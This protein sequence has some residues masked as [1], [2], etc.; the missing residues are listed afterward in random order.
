M[1]RPR[2]VVATVLVLIAIA[3][4]VIALVLIERSRVPGVPSEMVPPSWSEYRTSLGHEAHI[5]KDHIECRDCHDYEKEGFRSPGS[6][7]C[8]RCHDKQGSHGHGGGSKSGACLDCH[9]FAPNKTTPTCISCHAQAQ[10]H[11]AK[12]EHHDTTRCADCHRPHGEPS[13]VEKDCK[14]CHEELS[15]KHAAHAGSKGC[16]DCHAPHAP[17]AAAPATCSS[18]HTSPSGPKP[19][20]HE[21]CSTCHKPHEFVAGGSSV[22]S[23]CHGQKP[24]L[25]AT[26]VPA[27]AA[28]TSC[29]APHAP[30]QAAASCTYCHADV[31]VSHGGGQVCVACHQPHGSDVAA[32][33]A[34]PCTTCHANVAPTDDAGHS[35]HAE[36]SACHK[37]HALSPP[38][39]RAALCSSCHA[40]EWSLSSSSKGHSQCGSCHGGSTA[41]SPA[42]AQ[43]CRGCHV[44]EAATAPSGHLAVMTGTT[45]A[46][47]KPTGHQRCEA[48]H[49]PH[50]GK[51]LAQATCVSCHADHAAGPHGRI[52]GGCNACHRPHGPGGIPSPPACVSCHAKPTLPALHSIAGHT[53]CSSCHGSAHAPPKSDRATCTAGSC[54]SDR[55]SHQPGVSACAGCHTFRK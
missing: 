41:H 1:T 28:C 33:V 45:F 9:P 10:D 37:D 32:R 15:D 44:N 2:K 24:T 55:S 6:S 54:H 23:D 51:P 25:A 34:S 21:A 36:C 43:P 30:A 13:L 48:C 39:D 47:T 38:A 27:H 42:P 4:A 52:A 18:C 8:V 12:I 50:S 17:A 40:N 29:H 3:T 49:E 46:S 20:S 19:A 31:H 53:T 14:A 16:S 35:G 11:A 7:G 5:G 22:C 26:S